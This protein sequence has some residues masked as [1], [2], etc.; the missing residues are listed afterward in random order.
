MNSTL[1]QTLQLCS[2]MDDAALDQKLLQLRDQLQQH[3]RDMQRLQVSRRA[4][5]AAYSGTARAQCCKRNCMWSTMDCR[6]TKMFRNTVRNGFH[7]G[8]TKL[9]QHW[10]PPHPPRCLKSRAVKPH[11][12]PA[13]RGMAMVWVQMPIQADRLLK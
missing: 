7:Y 9:R 13:T 4:E 6:I 3:E 8:Q 10:H 12:S 5:R 2:N 1:Q 11:L